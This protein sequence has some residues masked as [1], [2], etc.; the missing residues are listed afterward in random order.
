MTLRVLTPEAKIEV[1]RTWEDTKIAFSEIKERLEVP[2]QT[3]GL[4][5]PDPEVYSFCDELNKID[6]IVTSQSCSGH[7]HKG[8]TPGETSMWQGELWIAMSS[9]TR[10][11]YVNSIHRLQLYPCIDRTSLVFIKNWYDQADLVFDGMNKGQEAFIYSQS[12]ILQFFR[13]IGRW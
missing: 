2:E 9:I 1:M 5:Y 7:L 10:T 12:C 4:G 3:G 13:E 6:G 11:A 8:E